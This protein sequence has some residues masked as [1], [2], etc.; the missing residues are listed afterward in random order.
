MNPVLKDIQNSFLYSG[1]YVMDWLLKN[2]F[3]LQNPMNK[4]VRFLL[5]C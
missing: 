5:K 4:S 1:K 2:Y 3:H